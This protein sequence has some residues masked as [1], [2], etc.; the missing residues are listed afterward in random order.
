MRPID[1]FDRS[2]ARWPDRACLID[3]E[4][5]LS[6]SEVRAKSSGLA[7]LIRA[8]EAER[9]GVLAPN[10]ADA[11]VAILAVWRSGAV[12]IPANSRLPAPEIGAFLK[13]AGCDLLVV[14]PALRAAGETAAAAAGCRTMCFN[15]LQEGSGDLTPFAPPGDVSLDD[16]SVVFGTGGTTGTPKAAECSHRMWQVLAANFIAAIDHQG[17]PVHLIAAPATH[18]AG[19]VAMPLIALGATTVIVDRAEPTLVLESIERHAVTTLFLPPTAIYGLLSHP[20]I[21]EFDLR[22]LQN[23]I[24]AAAPMSV[25]KLKEAMRVFGPVMVQTFGQAEAPMLCTILSRDEHVQ[26]LREGND[27]RLASCGRPGLLT[28]VAILDDDGNLLPNGTT[29]EIAVAGDLVMLGYRGDPEA[30]RAARTGRWH[31]TGDLGM[32]DEQGFVYITDRKRDIIITGGFN[33]YPSQV[34]QVIWGHPAVQDCAVIG[35]PDERW[36]E[37]VVAVVELKLGASCSAEEI[38]SLCKERLDSVRAPKRVEF[39]DRL[40]RSAVGKVLKKEIRARPS[41]P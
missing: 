10:C 14:H 31:R 33:V 17:V 37:A 28:D 2:C 32:I 9:V 16:P 27:Q 41:L 39:W 21:A 4:Q 24:Y 22:S 25:D 29:G 26:A 18:A 1:W 13:V 36:G 23:L 7:R 30:T 3:D 12:W 35:A 11:L 40:P 8:R 34:E 19:V 5:R 20:R 15:E 38:I 6:Y